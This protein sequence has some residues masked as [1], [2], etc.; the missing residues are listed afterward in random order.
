[1]QVLILPKK[2]ASGNE[3]FGPVLPLAQVSAYKYLIHLAYEAAGPLHLE[4]RFCSRYPF[5]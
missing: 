1:M 2:N 4:R 5:K 3:S